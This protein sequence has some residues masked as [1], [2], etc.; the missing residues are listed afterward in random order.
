MF[1]IPGPLRTWIGSHLANYRAQNRLESIS[2]PPEVQVVDMYNESYVTSNSC[3]MGESYLLSGTNLDE[4]EVGKFYVD[5][6]SGW[7]WRIYDRW[8]SHS[9][10][11]V[12]GL[13]QDEWGRSIEGAFVK[14]CD[15][16]CISNY[17]F[18]KGAI[19]NAMKK[20]NSL[21]L[22]NTHYLPYEIRGNLCFCCSGG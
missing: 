18:D 22:I 17:N 7:N 3:Y 9:Y 11:T 14:K 15:E 13:G 2:I 8:D 6:F 12:S 1:V 20:Y 19:N 10:L 4:K 16:E 5:F 21:Y